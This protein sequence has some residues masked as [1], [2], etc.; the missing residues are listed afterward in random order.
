MV[1]KDILKGF[2]GTDIQKSMQFKDNEYEHCN[3][4]ATLTEVSYF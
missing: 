2:F 3:L 1:N 4:E